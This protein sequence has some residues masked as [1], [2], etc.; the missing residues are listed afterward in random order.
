[1]VNEGDDQRDARIPFYSSLSGLRPPCV[2]SPL[3]EEAQEIR[4]LTILP[5][6]FTSIVHVALQTHVFAKN[7]PLQY[8]AL[9]Y[10]W[11]SPKD[12]V[13]VFVRS[14]FSHG[15]IGVTQNL[16]EALRYLR[17][18]DKIRTL[19]IDAICVNQLD[20]AERSSQVKRMA[21]IYSTA[22]RVV[23]WLG[24]GSDG[25][26]LAMRCCQLIS[27]NI[28]VD[29]VREAVSPVS[30]DTHWANKE[31]PL[32]FSGME[33][34]AI[35]RLLDRDWF[36]RLWIW[37][38]VNLASEVIVLCGTDVLSWTA[39]RDTVFSI[40]VKSWAQH[41]DIK[42]S[43]RR[44][45]HSLCKGPQG[46]SLDKLIENTKHSICSDPRDSI[47]ALFSLLSAY[48]RLLTIEPDYSKP[49]ARI[50]EEFT[51]Y[52]I[53]GRKHLKILSTIETR[54]EHSELP[55]WIPNL[56]T[57]RITTPF[58]RTKF[59]GLSKASAKFRADACL[60]VCGRTIGTIEMT[61][62]FRLPNPGSRESTAHS[63]STELRRISSL[64]N[65][66]DLLDDE[67]QS[68]ARLCRVLCSNTVLEVI[69]YPGSDYLSLQDATNSLRETLRFTA[70][71][72]GSDAT[73]SMKQFI[74]IVLVNCQGRSLY[75]YLDGTIG[76]ASKYVT[77]GDKVV[78][79]LG[80]DTAMV[81][82]PF[83]E[84]QYRLI[85]EAVYDGAMDGSA[86]LGSLPE[87]FQLVLVVVER[88]DEEH[89]A[90][91]WRFLHRESGNML[92]EDPRLVGIEL[93]LGWRRNRHIEGEFVN[94]ETGE[95]MMHDPRLTAEFL[96]GRGVALEVFEIV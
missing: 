16:A 24:P 38:E 74:N 35:S 31:L 7:I 66:D 39:I 50:F 48:D 37:Q 4:L 9:S 90:W 80:C 88:Y 47:F 60:E 36:M 73:A 91:A 32:P 23:V 87:Q 14:P 65:L 84:N 19:W 69:S 57:P 54:D 68:L 77:L 78:V 94:D 63:V 1:M 29:W 44:L 93:P 13:D 72:F 64:L 56:S 58:T 26:T 30:T 67:S 92:A 45:L 82:R 42:W 43:D 70:E 28:T 71:N 12:P 6:V 22:S 85:G 5:G 17:Y 18:E 27:S 75:R 8:E 83:R 59:S 79:C 53:Q 81:L 20:I 10:T 33:L 21:D 15:T 61:E 11:G 40:Y 25:S 62:P 2:Y 52:Y 96:K 34:V 41:Y 55:S 46:L 3:N 89:S 51:R 49:P 86:F 95:R 76:L